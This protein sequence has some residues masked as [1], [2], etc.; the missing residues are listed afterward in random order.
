[1]K[2]FTLLLFFLF[3][4]NYLYSQ[5]YIDMM[6]DTTANFY[7][8]QKAFNDYW[9]TRN[10]NVKGK[11]YKQFKR[12]ESFWQSRIHPDG[13]IPRDALYQGYLESLLSTRSSNAPM[14][15]P[16]AAASSA[17]MASGPWP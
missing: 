14:A 8:I 2:R 12:W 16:S 13:E 17:A 4:V 6:Y 15:P 7:D 3:S 9:E 10:P 11:G 5:R 1:M